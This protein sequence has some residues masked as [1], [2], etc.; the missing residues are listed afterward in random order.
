MSAIRLK[1]NKRTEQVIAALDVL[2]VNSEEWES[3][4]TNELKALAPE[5]LAAFLQKATRACGTLGDIAADILIDAK[6]EP[7]R[8]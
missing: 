6:V 1:A 8:R 4:I 2:L 7:P 3:E 5:E